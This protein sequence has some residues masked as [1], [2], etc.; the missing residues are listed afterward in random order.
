MLRGRGH[1]RLDLG[2]IIAAI[3]GAV[4]VLGAVTW[5]VRRTSK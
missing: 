3:L 1:L 4:I 2:G 5:I